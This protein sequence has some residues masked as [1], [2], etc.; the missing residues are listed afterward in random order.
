MTIDWQNK[1]DQ[2]LF[3]EAGLTA[4]ADFWDIETKDN[5]ELHAM[6]K[7]TNRKTKKVDRK[8]VQISLAGNIY[9]LKRAS[10]E[11]FENI[12]N[13]FAAIKILPG[14]GLKPAETAACAFDEGQKQG[15]L[16]LKDLK[17]FFSI[18]EI[19]KKNTPPE[20][21]IDFISR[22]DEILGRISQSI[23]D[24]YQR[25]F[26]YPDWF[27]KHIYIKKGSNEI[28]LIDLERFLPSEQCPW[29]Y[30]S[31]LTSKTVRRKIM[32]KLRISLE[33][34]SDFLPHRYLREIL[35]D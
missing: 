5:L 32:K 2:T 21:L 20:T 27:A 16:I 8:I 11:A 3:A 26:F 17:D 13:E 33:R 15:F 34:E 30:R 6:R 35:P 31:A 7:H 14:F 22:K 10:D 28:A 29:Y 18:K 25:G 9:Y 19:L 23:N 1:N 24:I 4:F 12:K